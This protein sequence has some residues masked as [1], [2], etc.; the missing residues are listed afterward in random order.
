MRMVLSFFALVFMMGIF[1]G[2]SSVPQISPDGRWELVWHDEFESYGAPDETKWEHETGFVRNREK[3]YYTRELAN[4]RQ[5]N[6]FLIL[7]GRNEPYPNSSYSEGSDNWR[8]KN[9]ASEY[10]SGSI[11]SKENFRYGRLEMRAKLPTGQGVWPAFWTLGESSRNKVKRWPYCGEIDILENV[12]FEPERFHA[13]VH[14]FDKESNAKKSLTNSMV[15]DSYD[16][17]HIYAV[18]WDEDKMVFFYD[19]QPYFTFDIAEAGDD[20]DNP[21]RAPH[22]IILNLALGGSWGGEI[23][24][25][26]LPAQYVIDYVRVWKKRTENSAE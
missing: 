8:F 4:S 22:F 20:E 13:T 12:G 19:D 17:F 2:C 26:I 16:G 1:C 24:N 11:R 5:E 14:F 15:N 23:N 25:D 21:F 10:T 6:G 18:E 7:E 9:P 3:Q